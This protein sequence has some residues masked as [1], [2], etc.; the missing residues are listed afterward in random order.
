MYRGAA[1]I[2]CILQYLIDP[3]RIKVPCIIHNLEGY[4]AHLILSAAKPHHVKIKCIPNNM[5]R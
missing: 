5:E 4:D 3:K 1:I 2:R